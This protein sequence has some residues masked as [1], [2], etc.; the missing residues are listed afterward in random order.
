MPTTANGAERFLTNPFRTTFYF[1][2]VFSTRH[3]IVFVAPSHFVCI[4]LSWIAINVKI[5]KLWILHI[6]NVDHR[7][8]RVVSFRHLHVSLLYCNHHNHN[9]AKPK[10][11]HRFA[12]LFLQ[13]NNFN[14]NSRAQDRSLSDDVGKVNKLHFSPTLAILTLEQGEVS[15]QTISRSSFEKTGDR[16]HRF[17]STNNQTLCLS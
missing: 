4:D 10:L 5:T 14:V 3:S 6:I 12:F 16:F 13:M 2:S 15:T 11:S 1:I 8:N 17:N 9:G 7:F